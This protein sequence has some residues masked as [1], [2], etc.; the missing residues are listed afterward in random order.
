MFTF[1]CAYI[2]IQLPNDEHNVFTY[3]VPRPLS[4]GDYPTASRVYVLI[5]QGRLMSADLR[6]MW[7]L[8]RL[9]TVQT[10]DNDL[11]PESPDQ[12]RIMSFVSTE[13]DANTNDCENL[14]FVMDSSTRVYFLTALYNMVYCLDMSPSNCS[15]VKIHY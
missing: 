9:G 11:G 13:N 10:V 6:V 2:S 3:D 5:D 4:A 15:V 1:P 7:Y 14:N 12:C 8:N